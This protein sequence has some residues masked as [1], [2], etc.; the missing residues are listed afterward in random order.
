MFKKIF[1]LFVILFFSFSL[2]SKQK[3]KEKPM[4]NVEV[5]VVGNVKLEKAIQSVSVYEKKLLDLMSGYSVKNLLSFTPGFISITGGNPGQFNYTYARGASANQSIVLIDGF[6]LIDSANT[7]GINYSL[8]SSKVFSKVEVVRGPLSNI[9]GSNAMGG[10]VNMITDEE[11]GISASVFYGSHS[12]YEANAHFKKDFKNLGL[13][14][15]ASLLNYSDGIVND[16]FKNNSFNLKFNYK[17]DNL[18]TGILAYFNLADSGIPYYMGKSTPNR[19]Y[20][21]NNVLLG[22]PLSFYFNENSFV[23]LKLSYNYN[24]YEFEDNDDIYYPYFLTESKVY[25]ANLKY[26]LKF[27]RYFKL[28]TGFEYSSQTVLNKDVSSSP[29]DNQKTN[30]FSGF[31][32]LNFDYNNLVLTGSL[33]YDKYK[34][35][36][37][38]I[39]PQIGASYMFG[40][41]LRLK[42]S[43]SKSFRVPT[44]PELLNPYWG[45]PELNPEKGNSFE[46]GANINTNFALFQI[47]YFDSKYEDL[48]G[49]NPETWK[50]S[51]INKADISGVEVSL[52]SYL[53]NSVNLILSYTHL[54]T[55]DY[56][57]ERELIRRPKDSLG[58]FISYKNKYFTISGDI[59]Y[60]GKRLDYNEMLFSVQEVPSYN[61]FNFSLIVPVSDN[62]E[63]FSRLTNAF[64]KEY[65][66]ILGYP[67][68]MRRFLVGLR[69]SLR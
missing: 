24:K 59:V 60:V 49:F 20:K 8:F 55:F 27:A 2:I 11:K 32:N 66:E 10:A 52:N 3:E 43:Y 15:N 16:K 5:E 41:I 37:S 39:S 40:K 68:P 22:I 30:Y 63:L 33:R 46:I 13:S 61:T 28:F 36:D 54:T 62:F 56:Q 12:T 64:D 7:L 18:K 57:Y 58:L 21:Q 14:F 9:Y 6:K 1:L 17:S 38:N 50:F 65:E 42:A 26:N 67:A 19:G 4:F 31:M 47:T 48:I 51:N 23:D 45:N 25:L 69:Y 44:L 34:D 35:V 53:F 29:V